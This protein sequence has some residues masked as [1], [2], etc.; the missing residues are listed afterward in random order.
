MRRDDFDAAAATIRQ[1]SAGE[2]EARPLSV[3]AGRVAVVG[4]FYRGDQITKSASLGKS[5]DWLLALAEMVIRACLAYHIAEMV[6][7]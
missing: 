2:W 1:E 3:V 6:A 7:A 4:I 5:A